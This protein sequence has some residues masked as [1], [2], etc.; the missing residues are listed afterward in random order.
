MTKVLGAALIVSLGL[1]GACGG[2]NMGT[3][4]DQTGDDQPGSDAGGSGADASTDGFV[5]LIMRDWSLNANQEAYRCVRI[6]VPEDMWVTGF[7]ALSPTGTHHEVLTISDGGGQ[8]GEY[9]CNAGSLDTKMLYAAGVNTDDLLFP[10]GVA[11]HLAKGQLINLNLH[12]F[13]LSDKA[14]SGTSGILVKTVDQSQVVNEADMEFAGTFTIN[15][16]SDNTPH[17][18]VGGC[19]APADWHIFTLWPHMHQ[20]AIHQKLTVDGNT[21]LDTDY[22]FAEQKNYPMA[23]TLISKGSKIEVTCTYQNDTGSVKHFGESSTDE[24]CFTGM[25]KYPADGNVFGCA[26]GTPGF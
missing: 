8:L 17:T 9:N 21:L 23:D 2:K 22:Q 16:P 19:N 6:A 18:A 1:A 3:G 11:T 20:T 25:Y 15:I 26:S 12:L 5:P 13:D 7:R 14:E 4:D 10:D 24:M